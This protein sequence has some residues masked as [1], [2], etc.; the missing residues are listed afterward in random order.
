MGHSA[1]QLSSICGGRLAC[2]LSVLDPAVKAN[3]AS[4][5]QRRV[6]KLNPARWPGVQAASAV[7]PASAAPE[8]APEDAAPSLPAPSLQLSP[9]GCFEPAPSE[10]EDAEDADEVNAV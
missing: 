2:S 8:P 3:S 6:A 4:V 1:Q 10:S 7:S 5:V 9:L